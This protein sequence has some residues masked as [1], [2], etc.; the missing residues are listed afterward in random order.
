MLSGLGDVTLIYIRKVRK[1]ERGK[2]TVIWV[3]GYSVLIAA[4]LRIVI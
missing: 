2:C 1:L 3:N 4:I